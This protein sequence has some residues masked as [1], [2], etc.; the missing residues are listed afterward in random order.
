MD[1]ANV[2]ASYF[3]SGA[4]HFA[5]W[6]KWPRAKDLAALVGLVFAML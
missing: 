6:H 2:P 1:V 5:H 3:L 4:T